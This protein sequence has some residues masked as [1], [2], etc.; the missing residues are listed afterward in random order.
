M[1]VDDEKLVK[2]YR[3]AAGR[4]P[5]NLPE[6][7]PDFWQ[8]AYR[9]TPQERAD[10]EESLRLGPIEEEEYDQEELF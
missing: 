4:D 9:G 7:H 3:E 2:M 1:I 5:R 10:L 8:W 6:D